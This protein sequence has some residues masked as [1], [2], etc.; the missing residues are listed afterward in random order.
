MGFRNVLIH[1]SLGIDLETVWDNGR[2]KYPH[3]KKQQEERIAGGT[4]RSVIA[5]TVYED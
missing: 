3:P 1:D 4:A 2:E 5:E